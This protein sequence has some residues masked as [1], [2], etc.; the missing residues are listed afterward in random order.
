MLAFL[1]TYQLTIMLMLI[2]MCILT[3]FFALL[4]V[5]TS[6]KRRMI[7]FVM[8]MGAAFL[9]IADRYAYI[10]RGDESDLGYWMVRI[11]NFMVFFMSIFES[12]VFN[13][14]LEDL[15]T[16]EGGLEKIPRRLR[17]VMLSMSR[18][19]IDIVPLS[20]S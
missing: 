11:A 14:Y 10:Y 17:L 18:P 4:M 6:T 16:D 2:G 5:N 15:Y 12:L 13:F 8:E 7:L 20:R 1:Q 19:F 9:L 3:A